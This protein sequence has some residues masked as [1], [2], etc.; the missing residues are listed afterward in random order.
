MKRNGLIF[1][2]L[3]IGLL[4]GASFVAGQQIA[5]PPE[6][7]DT[8]G[9]D[10]PETVLYFPIVM[11][12]EP[13]LAP[14]YDMARFIKGDGRLYEVQHSGG[15]QA[16]HQTQFENNLFFH[17][18]GNESYAEWEELWATSHFIYRGTDTSPGNGHYYT[19]RDEGEYGSKWAPRFW[20]VGQIFERN[21][22]VMFYNKSDCSE[23]VGGFQRS[24]LLFE[25]YHPYYTFQS[26]LRLANVAQLA[27]LTEPNGQPEERYYY[28]ENYGLVGWSSRTN[29]FSYISEMHNS[30]QRPNNAR[31]VIPCLDQSPNWNT[32]RFDGPLPYWPG[33][34]RR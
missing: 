21:P 24:W 26:G 1:L 5:S 3:I 4:W 28:A 31:E 29:G 15:A 12:F 20:N 8:P 27:W 7:T 16:R 11:Y 9:Q 23:V 2:L 32:R 17:T 10:D 14:P 25:A 18:K 33:N 6:L 22:H 34:H 19:L 30:G 13:P